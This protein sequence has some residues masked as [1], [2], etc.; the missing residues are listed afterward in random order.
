[1]GNKGSKKKN[2][3]NSLGEADS[4]EADTSLPDMPDPLRKMNRKY[5]HFK[6]PDGKEQK[7]CLDHFEIMKVL[8]RGSFGKVM[9]VKH[10]LNK[11]IYA[12]KS[13]RKDALLKRNQ[14]LHTKTERF[15][16]QH[17]DHPFH[18]G[19]CFAFQTSDKLFMVLEFMEG[20]ELFFWLKK[21]KRFSK[22]RAKLYCAEILLALDCLHKK[23]IVYRDLKPENILMDGKGHLRLADFG[24]SKEGV[25][26][27][28]AGE[29]DTKTFCGTPE[30]LAPEIL[31]NKGHGKAVDWWSLGTLLYEMMAGLP[32]FYTNNMQKMYQKILDSPLTFPSHINGAD[33]KDL[34]RKL[35]IRDP[36]KRLGSGTTGGEEIKAHPFFSTY[37]GNPLTWDM[38]L[39]KEITPEFIPPKRAAEDGDVGN[40][41][42]E[43][44]RE[45]ARVSV[46]QMSQASGAK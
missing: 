23:D 40:F 29:G 38:V 8:G 5:T 39:S 34:I 22:N 19:L 14:I 32:P 27:A 16:L 12:M 41:D 46:V 2:H 36:Q 7:I 28:G 20:G 6:R 1:M 30:Y 18:V 24:L 33:E 4:Y 45:K 35:L 25:T 21:H 43:F 26:A 44:T 15:I 3:N 13:L 9:L 37:D 31:I 17:I 10:K 42:K 11:N